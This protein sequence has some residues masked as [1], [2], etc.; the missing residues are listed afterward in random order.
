[1]E[2]AKHFDGFEPQVLRGFFCLFVFFLKKKYI[3]HWYWYDNNKTIES[4]SQGEPGI[5]MT[6]KWQ[7]TEVDQYL[8]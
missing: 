7:I 5:W 8:G 1:M 6:G 2:F 4:E 3:L